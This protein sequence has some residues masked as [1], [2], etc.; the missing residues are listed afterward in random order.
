LTNTLVKCGFVVVLGSAELR[1]RVLPAT[2]AM[3]AAGLIAV[4]AL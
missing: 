2:A 1:K 4:I 3:I